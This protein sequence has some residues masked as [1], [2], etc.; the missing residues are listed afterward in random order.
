MTKKLILKKYRPKK[1]NVSQKYCVA[2]DSLSNCGIIEFT[3]YQAIPT[4]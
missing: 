1:N 3:V 4:G 2:K